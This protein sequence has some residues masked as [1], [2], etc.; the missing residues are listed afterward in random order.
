M[1]SEQERWRAVDDMLQAALERA[2]QARAAFV[3]EACGDDGALRDA[4][5][6]LLR[7]HRAAGSF[8]EQPVEDLCVVPWEEVVQQAGTDPLAEESARDR[9]GERIGPYRIIGHLGR[10]GMATVYLADR[11]DG[12]WQERVAIKVIRRGRDTEDTVRRFLAERQI[13]SSLHHP[14]IARFLGGGT[15]ADGLPYLVLEHIEGTAIT[16]YCDERRADLATRLRLFADVCRAVEFAH[17]SLVVHRDLKPSNILVTAGGSVKLLDFGIA[18]I[19]DPTAVGE[20]TLTLLRPLTPEYASPEQVSGD[21]VTTSSD[22]YQLGLLLSEL[23]SGRRPYEVRTRSPARL[24][25]AIAT[26]D[27]QRPSSLVTEAAARARQSRAPELARRLRGDLDLIVLTAV[28]RDPDRRYGSTEA[29]R[30]DLE[31]F[32]QAQ[33]IAARPDSLTYRTRRLMHRKPWVLPV[34]ALL[35]VAVGGYL[36]T[37]RHHARELEQER[38]VARLEASRARD[39]QQL[40][41]GLFRSADPFNPVDPI[42]GDTVTVVDALTVGAERMQTELSE[43]PAIRGELLLAI[44]EVLSDLGQTDRSTAL[45]ESALAALDEAGDSVPDARARSLL[46]L[47]QLAAWRGAPDS[48]R[49]LYHHALVVAQ[50]AHPAGD[51]ALAPFHAR[52]GRFFFDVGRLDSSRIHLEQA[53][54]L[55]RRTDPLPA[56]DLAWTLANL[57]DTRRGLGDLGGARRAIAEARVLADSVLGPDAAQTGFILVVDATVRESEG[58]LASADSLLRRSIA[59]LTLRLGRDNP[60]TLAA[61]NN[62]AVL[63]KTKGDDAEAEQLFRQLLEVKRRT[64]GAHHRETANAQQNL[65]TVLN[66]EGRLAEA[67]R[68]AR[69]AVTTYR[70]VLLPDNPLLAYPLLTRAEIALKQRRFVDADHVAREATGIL[71]AALPAGNWVT[72]VADCRLGRALVGEGRLAE[73]RPLLDGAVRDLADRA[74]TAQEPYLRRCSQARTA[75]IAS[76]GPPGS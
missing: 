48:A 2:P 19:L 31:R 20:R 51:P 58:D 62:L 26:A 22:V 4:V 49:R 1:E 53:V 64:L 44:A 25:E 14:H 68:L 63:L 61:M 75:L 39:V 16:R 24:E 36:L 32:E 66:R 55:E 76:S 50:D 70:T 18:K 11:V 65:A 47:G 23:L 13:L 7:A 40:L 34:V 30:L 28:H 56:T 37:L 60:N 45:A 9:I 10:G 67:D 5:M 42:V 59:V 15:T 29:L 27:R 38:N 71:H 52:I 74:G 41:T 17:R 12:Q 73:A 72:A 57:A 43:R 33:P 69:Q 35:A 46:Q 54:A 21:P 3:A 6:T 8:L